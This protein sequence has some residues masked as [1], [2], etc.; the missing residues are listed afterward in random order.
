MGIESPTSLLRA[1]KIIQ[2]NRHN[3]FN[4]DFF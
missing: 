3:Q 2:D 4:K 1:K